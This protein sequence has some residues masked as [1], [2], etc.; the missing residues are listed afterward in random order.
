[1]NHPNVSQF[2]ADAKQNEALRNN[3]RA[4]M[5]LQ[6]CIEVAES[7]GYHLSSKELQAGLDQMSEQE[8]RE[9]INPGV[10]PR[11]HIQPR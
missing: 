8:L 7:Y 9:L 5:T 4:A 1:M 2:L 6:S 11:R 10:A 3:L